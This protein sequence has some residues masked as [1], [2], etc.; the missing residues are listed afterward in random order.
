MSAAFWPST[1][2][3]IE[4]VGNHLW[5]STIF[6]VAVGLLTLVLRNNRAQVRHR[7]W[8][9]ASLK[10]LVPFAALTAVGRQFGWESVPIVGPEV[11]LVID[12]MSQ[13]FSQ[14]ASSVTVAVAPPLTAPAVAPAGSFIL[15]LIWL[16]GFTAILLHWFVQWRGVATFVRQRSPV[17]EGREVEIL[18]RLEKI[19][20]IRRPVALVTSE[21][22]LEPGVFGILKPVL[23]WPQS[24]GERLDDDQMA[25]ILAHELSHVRRRDNLAAAVHT[26]IQA[27]F[28]F[29]PL[30]WFVGA[31]LVDE[32]ERSCDQDVIRLGSEPRVYAESILQTCRF[33][34][35]SPMASVAGVTSSNLGKRIE[36]IMKDPGHALNGWRKVL[37]MS[38]SIVTI[39]WPLVVGMLSAPRL[40]AQSP[41]EAGSGPT[42]EVASVK[43]SQSREG[44]V[45]LGIQPGGRFTARNVPLRMLIQNAYQLQ[46]SQLIGGPDWVDSDRFDVVAK[47]AGDVPPTAIGPGRPAGALQLMLQALLAE[48]FNLKVHE[49]TRELPI[50]ALL[51]ARS[52]GKLGTQLRPA[53]VD[54]AAVIASA[55]GRGAQPPSPPQ[56]G[57]HPQ[58][59]MRI[60]PGQMSGG[61]LLMSQFAM[62]LSLFVRRG[63]VDRT[64]LTGPFDI[65]LTW[66]PDQMPQGPPPPG[67]PPLPPVDPHG[68][69][70]FTAVQEQ[71]GLKL[72]STKGP[73]D[74][75]VIDQVEPPI[76]D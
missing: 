74:V 26:F 53:A 24:M 61:G 31:R 48:R 9:A 62:S 44:F 49:E 73:V 71:L 15:L 21:T 33:Y 65:E 2:N 47:A 76:P 12:T 63:V 19:G 18:R 43:Q 39:A 29:H 37:L 58:C 54:C 51:L 72:D 67:A 59:G 27:A 69:S 28:W 42:F 32:R 55:R 11:M 36:A 7:L 57:E 41:L 50:Y 52:D 14:P 6:V 46:D 38:A 23:L 3:G 70:I 16:G 35:G 13:P 22:S 17:S 10:F 25:A 20:G 56:P 30:V 64:G 75:L 66:T 8:L 60:G 40:D 34:I 68:P 1:W 45:Q 4:L 5:Q